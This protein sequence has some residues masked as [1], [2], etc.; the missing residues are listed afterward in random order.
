MTNG[1]QRLLEEYELESFRQSSVYDV[2]EA[3]AL[4]KEHKP[5]R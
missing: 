5:A 2:C 3:T 4:S 1:K